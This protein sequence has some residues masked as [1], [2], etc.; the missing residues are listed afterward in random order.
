MV[1]LRTNHSLLKGYRTLRVINDERTKRALFCYNL[2]LFKEISVQE[3]VHARGIK[4]C[5]TYYSA[6]HPF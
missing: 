4:A 5:C 6:R 2:G 3:H 1:G